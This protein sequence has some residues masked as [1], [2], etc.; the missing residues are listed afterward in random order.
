VTIYHPSSAPFTLSILIW[1]PLALALIVNALPTRLLGKAAAVASLAT[2]G[3]AITFVANF[4]PSYPGLQFVTDKV[5]ISALGIHYALGMNGLNV[6]LV[7]LT[8]VLF[9][10][11]LFWS[12][13]R[14]VDRP[15]LYYFWFALA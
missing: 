6:A 2:V 3:V 4:N 8:T 13:M 12:S 15:H 11:S 14:E 9:S 5:W 7:L 10:V 1:L